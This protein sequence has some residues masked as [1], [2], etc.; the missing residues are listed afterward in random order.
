MATVQ[1]N[2]HVQLSE[3]HRYHSVPYPYAG[4]KAKILYAI[5]WLI[6]LVTFFVKKQ[7][8]EFPPKNRISQLNRLEVK[9][10]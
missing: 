7:D 1:R 3:D 10:S 8:Q 6:F 9:S 2:S 5:S 4:K